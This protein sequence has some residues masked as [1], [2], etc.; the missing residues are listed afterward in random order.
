MH[1]RRC[2]VADRAVRD[3]WRRLRQ[4]RRVQGHQRRFL[5]LDMAR[6]RADA[7]HPM[8]DRDAGQVGQVAD[9][10]QQRRLCQP[11][12]Q[13]RQQGLATGQHPRVIAMLG[14]Q[15]QCVLCRFGAHVVE[16]L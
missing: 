2:P 5:D 13:R 4:Q 6:Q 12:A 9:V 1:R 14:Q 10:D 3:V 15:G 16:G 8:V 7:Q 11:H